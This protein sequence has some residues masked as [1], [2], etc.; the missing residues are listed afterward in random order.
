MP[1]APGRAGIFVSYVSLGITHI[2]EGVDHLLFVFALLV[3]IP[4]PRRLFWT[5][6]AFTLGH[7]ITFAAASFGW[8]SLPSAPV[9]AGIALS[10]VFLA[11]ALSCSVR[12]SGG[13]G[14]G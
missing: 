9:E 1:E 2:L 14:Q 8:V 4:Q 7:S 3:L 5:V 12:A 11:Y 13:S 10:I 6:I